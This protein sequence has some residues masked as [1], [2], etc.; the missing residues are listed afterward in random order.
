MGNLTI[1]VEEAS[2]KDVACA[3]A[4]LAGF[5][6]GSLAGRVN[7]IWHREISETCAYVFHKDTLDKVDRDLAEAMAYHGPD[8]VVMQIHKPGLKV[9][10]WQPTNEYEVH[11][12]DKLVNPSLLDG[13]KIKE[14]IR[15]EMERVENKN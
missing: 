1:R 3:L 15:G 9:P 13:Y 11:F 12:N 4:T 8:V 5:P 6:K 14:A 2:D 10:A 7:N